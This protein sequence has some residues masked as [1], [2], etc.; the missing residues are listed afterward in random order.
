MLTRYSV[1]VSNSFRPQP[2]PTARPNS[3]KS[4]N[5][6][7]EISTL[8][9]YLP[10]PPTP[11]TQTTSISPTR[12]INPTAPK[13]HQPR[14]IESLPSYN[15]FDLFSVVTALLPTCRPINDIFSETFERPTISLFF[16]PT[17]T[18]A[19]ASSSAT[20]TF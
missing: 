7:N 12:N 20:A 11:G 2:T 14:A 17:K 13:S 8:R 9:S 1:S 10:A 18:S 16:Q 19:H 5:V 6:S 3:T 15:S 4:N